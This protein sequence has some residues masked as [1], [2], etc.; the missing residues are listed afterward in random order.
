MGRIRV[1]AGPAL[2][3]YRHSLYFFRRFLYYCE[4]V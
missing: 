1:R 2:L 4:N 3:L